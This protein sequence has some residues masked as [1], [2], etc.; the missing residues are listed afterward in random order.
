MEEIKYK[1]APWW[2]K[3][4]LCFVPADTFTWHEDPWRFEIA[5]YKD[6]GGK[7]YLLKKR[8]YVSVAMT[9][10][11]YSGYVSTHCIKKED[12]RK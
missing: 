3:V 7:T 2:V 5:R 1:D 12:Y 9:F 4:C 11:E 6:F 8:F 10:G